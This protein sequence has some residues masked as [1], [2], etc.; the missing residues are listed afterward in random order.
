[1]NNDAEIRPLKIL[2]YYSRLYPNAWKQAD[3]MR[4]DRGKGLPFWPEWCF[5]PLAGAYSIVSSEIYRQGINKDDKLSIDQVI[6]V[7][8]IGALAAWRVTQGIYRFDPDVYR[9]VIKTPLTGDLP[10]DIFLR[11]PEWCIYV[12]TP[13]YTMF[14]GTKLHGFFCF[15]EYDVNNYDKELR[16]M[17]DLPTDDKT[18][19][20]PAFLW[21][22]PIILND[23]SLEV[24]IYHTS[25]KAA[26]EKNAYFKEAAEYAKNMASDVSCLVSLIIYICST[27]SEIG[28]EAK[29]PKFPKPKNTKKGHRLFPPYKPNTWDIGVKMGAA[30]RRGKEN[31]NQEGIGTSGRVGEAGAPK[32]PHIRRAHWHTYWTGPRDQPDKRD[33]HVKWMPPIAVKADTGDPSVTVRPVK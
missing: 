4:Q 17:L 27:N 5:L 21:N 7:S 18:V 2:N 6:D 26:I 11:L 28:T 10:V 12:E 23:W 14:S 13:G 31:T 19:R 8:V 20:L 1:M 3:E 29:R 30:L 22:V 32:S 24:A 15:M 25:E 16:I 33:F 9:E